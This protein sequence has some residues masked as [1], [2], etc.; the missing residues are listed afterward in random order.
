MGWGI[1]NRFIFVFALLLAFANEHVFACSEADLTKLK[2]DIDTKLN[3][4]FSV[5]FS[6]GQKS[7]YAHLPNLR[8]DSNKGLL[9]E[10]EKVM[11]EF[12]TK[13][14][15]GWR[16]KILCDEA[17]E[18][19]LFE[20]IAPCEGSI[21][22]LPNKAFLDFIKSFAEANTDWTIEINAEKKGEEIKGVVKLMQKGT[23]VTDKAELD[24]IK[25][26]S[27]AEASGSGSSIEFKSE[28]AKIKLAATYLDQ[29]HHQIEVSDLAPKE[30]TLTTKTVFNA[31]GEEVCRLVLNYKDQEVTK[32]STDEAHKAILQSIAYTEVDG[33]KVKCEFPDC[34][35]EEG[36]FGGIHKV[37]ASYQVLKAEATCSFDE[38]K[39][40]DAKLVMKAEKTEKDAKCTGTVLVKL[41]EQGVF[42]INDKIPEWLGSSDWKSEQAASCTG[43]V[44]E[45]TDSSFAAELIVKIKDKE[46]K[47]KCEVKGSSTTTAG[48]DDLDL[49][50]DDESVLL[51]LDPKKGGRRVQYKAQYMIPPPDLSFRVMPGFN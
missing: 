45:A 25:W 24:K 1:I 12:G 31:K 19:S 4:K 14:G 5:T 50:L 7:V 26:Q 49:D 22:N 21:P 23:E 41:G 38:P 32:D 2:R 20:K 29:A 9:P 42:Q 43:L 30:L 46:L 37:L 10:V 15:N 44:C 51:D 36:K 13:A 48:D 39:W 27:D 8:S 6:K 16:L 47:E 33:F 35:S 17:T 34:I 18:S 11:A 40:A 3:G 28:Q